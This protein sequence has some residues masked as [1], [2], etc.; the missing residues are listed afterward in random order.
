MLCPCMPARLSAVDPEAL[1]FLPQ[2]EHL[3][4][5]NNKIESLR[6]WLLK[7]RWLRPRAAGA[8]QAAGWVL[9]VVVQGTVLHHLRTLYLYFNE[10]VA[11]SVVAPDPSE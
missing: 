8:V 4:L 9:F 10:L 1:E 6:A 7:V 3:D 5:A 2:L 11:L